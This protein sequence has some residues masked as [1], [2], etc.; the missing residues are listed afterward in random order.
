MTKGAG[1]RVLI[2]GASIAGPSLG[3][4]LDRYGFDV[5]I[6]EKSSSLRDGGYPIDVRGTAVDAA[7]R[8]GILDAVREAH[9]DT[10]RVSF[11]SADGR[12]I[13][14]IR[15]EAITGGVEGRD[16]ELP[17]GGLAKALAH[18]TSDKVEYLFGDSIS[19]VLEQDD[20]LDITFESG[21]Q[22]TFDFL[23]G[24]DGL[25]SNVRRIV[26]GPESDFHRYLGWC[27]AGFT[28]PNRWNMSRETMLWNVPGRMASLYAV[29]EKPDRVYGFLSMACPQPSYETLRDEEKLR[30]MIIDGFKGAGWDIPF[31]VSELKNA[32]DS[33]CDSISQIYMP[34]WSKGRV[35]LVGDAAHATSFLSG[36]GSSC[37]L[38]TPYVLAGELA[39]KADAREAFESYET[40]TRPFVEENQA[41]AHR[42]T[43]VCVAGARQLRM[44]NMALRWVV[45]VIAKLHLAKRLGA[46]NRRATTALDLPDYDIADS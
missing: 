37:S 31:L 38:I 29:G 27:F 22:R 35:A 26:F 13:Q 20:Q 28:L 19:S 24:A 16:F 23:F 32:S 36:Q 5:T 12:P 4:W 8:M 7:A 17:R 43:V 34:S 25:H 3:Y 11:L 30:D 46:K 10:A 18:A 9:I 40:T 39:T 6:V 33:F 1:R 2:S 41:I 14:R 15:P 45:P 21:S 44:R 42:N